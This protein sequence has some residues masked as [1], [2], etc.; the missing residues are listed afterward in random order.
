MVVKID[1]VRWTIK[2]VD[3]VSTSDAKENGVRAAQMAPLTTIM[4]II[5]HQ[6][7]YFNKTHQKTRDL[8]SMPLDIHLP[9]AKVYRQNDS[10]NCGMF[11]I[12]YIDDILQSKNIR[13][14]HNMIAN[15][16]RQY[17]L[18]IFSNNCE[19]EP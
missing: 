3:S 10:V 18:E 12:G 14:K 11:M 19:S 2:M 5:C 7:N 13:V 15:M 4:P 17:A 1:L 16:S 8:T 9:K 6:I